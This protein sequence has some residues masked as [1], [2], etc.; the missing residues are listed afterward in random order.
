[1]P[2]A[3]EVYYSLS[4][5]WTYF[6]WPRLRRLVEHTGAALHLYPI[7]L[8]LVFPR[9]GGLPLK[10]RA[11]ARQAYRLAELRRWRDVLGEP[12]N[13]EPRFFPVDSGRAARCAI[14][15]RE[16]GGPVEPFSFAVLRAI[17]V[18]ERDAADPSTLAA[19]LSEA[20]ADADA[21]L[22]SADDDASAARLTAD[23]EAAVDHGVFGA[24]TFRVGEEL[25]WGQDRLNFVAR[26]LG[27][28]PAAVFGRLAS[29]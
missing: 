29:A 26:A 17:W 11:P 16:A 6:A 13:I 24:P 12:L 21:T 22:A 2:A 4:S 1:M 9:T 18:E 20:G 5:P 3:L 19:L 14:A 27:A 7:E 23:S 15:L 8:G 10:Q 28:D 25:F